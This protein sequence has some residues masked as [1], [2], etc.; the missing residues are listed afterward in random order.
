MDGEK[1]LAFARHRK[2]LPSGDFQRVQHQQLVVEAIAN[3]TKNLKIIDDFYN[4]LTA[5]SKNID[6]NMTTSE[7]MNLYNVGKS[8]ILSANN[9]SLINI[10]KTYLT[11]YDLTMYVQNLRSNVYTFQYYEQ[12]LEEITDAL[13]VTLELKDPTIVKTFN[14]SV[15]EEYEVPVVGKKYY[16]IQRNETIPSFTGQS[17]A[18]VRSWCES[19]NII[20]IT[21]Y[22]SEGD[23]GYNEDLENSVVI[24]QSIAKGRL[25]KDVSTITINV[26]KHSEN[27][28]S[29]EQVVTSTTT[30]S[31]S[32]TT[33]SNTLEENSS[34]TTTTKTETTTKSS[35]EEE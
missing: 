8:A 6:T 28:T 11:G 21:N 19:R 17:E 22:I 27:N 29:N 13:K 4:V 2:T 25:V 18:Y 10:Q 7:I 31:I 20:V 14:F 16:T 5:I 12:S 34:S 32:T 23:P 24:N 33:E 35:D 15:N 3:A 1:A 30:T 9:G 26:I